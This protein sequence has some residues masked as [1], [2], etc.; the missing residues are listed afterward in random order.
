MS[1]INGKG[2]AWKY[3]HHYKSND[4]KRKTRTRVLKVEPQV[5]L[6][7]VYVSPL[8]SE[9]RY[10]V[11]GGGEDEPQVSTVYVPRNLPQ[12][13]P[14]GVRVMDDYVA[15][16]ASGHSDLTAFCEQRGLRLNDLDSLIFVLTGMRGVDFRQRYQV[17][18]MDEL[19]RYTSL[20]PDEVA[21]RCGLGKAYN[22]YLTTKREYN[23]AP[24]EHRKNIREKGDE[25]KYQ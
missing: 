9:R 23:E 21:R 10:E 5:T 12:P 18:M 15:Y 3:R 11:T 17:R 13:K 25:G 14:T 6:D 20:T 2:D 22:L 16:L 8:K 7:D 4:T 24:M 1:T 19:L